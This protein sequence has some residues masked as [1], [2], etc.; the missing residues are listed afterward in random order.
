MK[1][2]ET[3]LHLL[4]FIL[5]LLMLVLVAFVVLQLAVGAYHMGYR[6]LMEPA[7]EKAP[8]TDVVV[9]VEQGMSALELGT[10]LEEKKLVDNHILFAVQLKI[11]AYADKLKPGVYTLNTSMTA[12][13]MMQIMAKEEIEETEE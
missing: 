13:K 12:E 11:S 8:G 9:E 3:T 10:Q 7:M 4:G 5:N 2:N 6:V 1:K